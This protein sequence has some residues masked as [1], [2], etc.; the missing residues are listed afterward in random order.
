MVLRGYGSVATYV[1]I[2]QIWVRA[3]GGRRGHLLTPFAALLLGHRLN[4]ARD[5]RPGLQHLQI[6][7]ANGRRDGQRQSVLH[8][9][10]RVTPPLLSR[11][12]RVG[13]IASQFNDAMDHPLGH[14]SKDVLSRPVALR[15][16]FRP[17][18]QGSKRGWLV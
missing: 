1:A 10:P 16:L 13:V 12:P 11:L 3:I 5:L 14:I 6:R 8:Q 2:R 4:R 9:F 7:H 15:V 18:I 17:R